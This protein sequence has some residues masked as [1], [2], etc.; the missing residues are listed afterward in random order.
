L[1]VS[2]R[3]IIYFISLTRN[4]L[5]YT[6]KDKQV[7]KDK[8]EIFQTY[9]IKVITHRKEESEIYDNGKGDIAD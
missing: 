9:L 4:E 2:V 7:A 5:N 8:E 6:K 3:G 1:H